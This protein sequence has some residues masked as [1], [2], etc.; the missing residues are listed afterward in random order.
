MKIGAA[1]D[2]NL[3]QKELDQ[4]GQNIDRA[5][6]ALRDVP[7][8]KPKYDAMRKCE[9][10][11]NAPLRSGA[12]HWQPENPFGMPPWWPWHG[13]EW[14]LSAFTAEQ[15]ELLRQVFEEYGPSKAWKES[16]DG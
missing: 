13:S 7:P 2:P 10:L 12:K 4:A 6:A 11:P 5:F 3:L 16:H 14:P 8:I 9:D 1:P 15:V